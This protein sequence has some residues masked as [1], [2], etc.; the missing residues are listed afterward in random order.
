[1]EGHVLRTVHG[2]GHVQA[3]R[4]GQLLILHGA[5]VL[6]ASRFFL[7]GLPSDPPQS[8]LYRY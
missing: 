2:A 3:P 4:Q 1:M 6:L 8:L 5:N 7:P